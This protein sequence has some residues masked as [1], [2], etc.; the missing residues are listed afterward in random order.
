MSTQIQKEAEDKALQ[1]M[2]C[3]QEQGPT[4]EPWGQTKMQGK[5]EES[6]GSKSGQE[7]PYRGQIREV[8]TRN[9][10]D[11]IDLGESDFGHTGNRL[12]SQKKAR[13]ERQV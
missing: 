10:L 3:E 7:W 12:R 11:P 1:H 4:K 5:N 13:K 2:G 9:K 6:H 8:L